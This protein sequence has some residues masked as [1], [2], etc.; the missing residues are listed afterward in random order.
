MPDGGRLAIETA[1]VHLDAA[2]ARNHPEI[3]PGAHVLLAVSDTGI[4]MDD[5][6][7]RHLFEPFFTT[8]DVGQGTGLG[9]ATVHGI[10][11]QSGGHILVDS[12]PGQGSTFKIYLPRAPHDKEPD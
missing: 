5:E 4:G 12:E 11:T 6:V 7:L 8:K 10:V 1:N 9:L 3:Q 2:W